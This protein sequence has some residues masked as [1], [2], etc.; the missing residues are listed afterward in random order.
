MKKI[1][2]VF[3]TFASL[4]LIRS[5]SLRAADWRW[6]DRPFVEHYPVRPVDLMNSATNPPVAAGW[7]HLS[8]ALRRDRLGD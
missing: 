2:S 5:S 3:I 7:E 8:V 1:T 6:L 4:L